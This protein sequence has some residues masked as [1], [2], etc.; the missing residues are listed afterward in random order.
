MI[1]YFLTFG[2]FTFY[3]YFYNEFLAVAHLIQL[4]Q[5]YRITKRP[6]EMIM[7]TIRG[8]FS[9]I[10]SLFLVAVSVFLVSTHCIY[11]AE[12]GHNKKIK[13]ITDASWLVFITMITVG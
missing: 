4:M 6:V 1:I 3:G 11:L 10:F 5:I 2:F 13:N 8:K 12:M 9:F 7:H